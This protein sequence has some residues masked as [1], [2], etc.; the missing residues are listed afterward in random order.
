MTRFA[1]LLLALTP[2]L[3]AGCCGN[4]TRAAAVYTGPT[5]T[6]SQVVADINANNQKLPTLWATHNY[7]ADVVDEKHHRHHVAGSGKLLYQGSRQMRLTGDS[8][9][10]LVFEIGSNA[11]TYW[12]KLGPEAGNT[13][14]WGTWADFAQADPDSLNIPIRPDMVLDVLGIGTINTNFSQLPAPV[15]RFDG[16]AD[17]YVF[18]WIGKLPDRWV[19]LREVYYDRKTKRPSRVVVYDLNGRIVMRGDLVQY[20]Q[21]RLE[22]I[23]AAQ[24]PWIAG[25]YVLAFPDSGSRIVFTLDQALLNTTTEGFDIKVPNQASFRMPPPD[26]SGVDRV[27][28]I[29][30]RS[31]D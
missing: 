3:L 9:V 11:Q 4:G 6:L 14:W 24:W 12:L 18:T 1:S 31:A 13:M 8:V 2:L 10:G 23:P 22:N 15:M 25:N 20:R 16:V 28:R 27:V 30:Q 5:Q 7:E 19:G 21:V 26:Q 29:G 17:A